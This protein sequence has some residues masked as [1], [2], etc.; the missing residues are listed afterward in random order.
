M[1]TLF[2]ALRYSWPVLPSFLTPLEAEMQASLQW[3]EMSFDQAKLL[4]EDNGDSKQ[5]RPRVPTMGLQLGK[6]WVE[7]HQTKIQAHL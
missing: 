1:C 2:L 5:M 6:N 4:M 3:G 7:E